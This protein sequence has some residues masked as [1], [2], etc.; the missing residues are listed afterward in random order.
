MLEKYG[1]LFLL[2][3]LLHA[4]FFDLFQALSPK[5]ECAK[6]VLQDFDALVE[7]ALI[8]YQVPGVA[9][10]V[11]VDG[12]VVYAKGFGFRDLE[13]KWLMDE[14]TIFPIG[15]CTKAFTTFVAGN[16]VDKGLIAWD[17]PVIDVLPQFRLWDQYATT[18]L[19]IRDLLTHRTGMPRHELV[20]YNSKMTKEE[21]LKRIRY[22]EPSYEIRER[23]QYI[24]LMYF[25]AGLA[26]EEAAGKSWEEMTR[27]QILNP[28]GMTHTNFSIEETQKGDNYAFPY[29]EKHDQ[30]RKMA[31]RNL[32]LIGP[33]ACLNSNVVDMTRW[34]QMQLAGGVYRNQALINPV[35]L[36]ELHAPQIIVP[37]VPECKEAMLYAYGMGWGVLS[38]RGYYFLSHDGISDGFT[39]VV[40]LLPSE[41]VGVIV[42]ANKNMTALS[43]YLSL[44][45]IDRVLNLSHHDW[46]KDGMDSIR[47]NK[48]TMKETRIREDQM[49]K[50]GTAPC[51]PLEEYA[52][53][54]ENPGYGKL[55]IEFVNG[56]LQVVYNDLIFV[57]EHWHYD[58]FSIEKEMQDMVISFEGTKVTFCNNADGDIGKVIIPFEPTATDIVFIRKPTEKLSNLAYL[59]QFTGAY[60]L[61]GYVVEITIRDRVLTAVI[62]GQPNYELVPVS[63]NAFNV[64]SMTGS[65]VRFLMNKNNKVDEVLLIHPYGT[66]SA[67]PRK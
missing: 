38:Y 18:N 32:S 52:G 12:H 39:S 49:R 17:Q 61:Y 48:E 24:Q 25:V 33:A 59:R 37:S 46:L 36:Q 7:K 13:N 14:N 28:L 16:L 9:I 60:E 3:A 6:G 27:E 10:G 30:L 26:M 1:L 5:A 23:Y 45:I 51:H 15:S 50:K 20:W 43:R 54:Y 47:K 21:M 44:E 8:D 65:T 19:T 41:N 35:T 22:L 40:G 29:G 57:L 66:F 67:N 42:L 4:G 62:P 2:P 34:M 56:K 55:Y 31:F 11:V 64:K 53:V 58:I 63:E